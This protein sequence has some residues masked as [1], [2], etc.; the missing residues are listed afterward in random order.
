MPALFFVNCCMLSVNCSP[1]APR[2]T[3]VS[4]KKIQRY[5]CPF[6]AYIRQDRA[7]VGMSGP[8]NNDRIH[9][10]KLVLRGSHVSANKA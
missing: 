5:L 8:E 7:E 9:V 2:H 6:A 3:F 1:P 10:R 4:Q